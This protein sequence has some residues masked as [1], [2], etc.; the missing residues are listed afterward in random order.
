MNLVA[1]R[2]A[3]KAL[4]GPIP[5]TR[6]YSVW[7]PWWVITS[8]LE[9]AQAEDLLGAL[10]GSIDA[11]ERFRDKMLPGSYLTLNINSV[12]KD[13]TYATVG[14][15]GLVETH[16]VHPSESIARVLV[17]LEALIEGDDDL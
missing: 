16:T 6:P 3:V 13:K 10:T 1:L 5:K 2:N 12:R 15:A 11:S 17:I 8:F 4:T 14:G 9:D 7:E